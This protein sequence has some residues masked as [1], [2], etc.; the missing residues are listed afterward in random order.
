MICFPPLVLVAKAFCRILRPYAVDIGDPLDPLLFRCMN[1]DCQK[2]RFSLQDIIRASSDNHA[3]LLR[4]QVQNDLALCLPDIILIAAAVIVAS[5]ENIPEPASPVFLRI[6][7]KILLIEPALLRNLCDKFRI[8]AWDV[9]L[10]RDLLT[11]SSSAASEF[12]ADGDDSA[13]ERLL[14]KLCINFRCRDSKYQF[15]CR[16]SKYQFCCRDSKNLLLT[17]YHFSEGSVN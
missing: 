17:V 15:C 16:D 12:A 8:V 14:L 3:V 13:H 1:E 4:G 5:N 9:Q 7:G 11:D 2:I 10:L 6:A